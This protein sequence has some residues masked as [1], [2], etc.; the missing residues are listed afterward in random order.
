MPLTL[1][2]LNRRDFCRNMLGGTL[3]AALFAALPKTSWANESKSDHWVFLS[4][5]HIPGNPDEER[6]T[7]NPNKNFAEVR[8]AV[9][10]LTDKPKGVIITGDFAFLQGKPE[11]YRQ[12]VKQVAPYLAAGVPV[13]IAFGNHDN[14]D[15]FYAAFTD[16]KREA[17]PVA[18]KH[19]TVLETPNANLFLLDSLYMPD[20]GS[21]FLGL[22]QLRWLRKELAARKDKPALL[23]AHH[24]LD[25]GAGTLMDREEFWSV[26]KGAKNVKAYIYG[27]TH[28][29]RQAVRDDVH[30]INLPALG[31]EFQLGKQPLG[32]TDVQLSSG[33][34]ELT[35][36]TVHHEHPKDGDVRKF[37]WLR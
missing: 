27:H 6:H 18:D 12:T 7:S 4:D 15:N 19:I 3:T 16:L 36:H 9:L 2:P 11:D 24:N 34:I 33:G 17:L 30:L 32:W 23:F 1:Q 31:W 20:A 22:P 26:I 10:K 5:T 28:I 35:L 14:I 8:D 29:Y 37:E 25:N 13:H 21:G